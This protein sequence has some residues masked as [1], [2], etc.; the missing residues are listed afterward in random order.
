MAIV[1]IYREIV[2]IREAGERAA[3]A[4]I[5][6]RLG[7]TP[8]KDSAKM[9]I[10]EDGTAVGSVG[11]GCVEGEVWQKAREVIRSGRPH[12]LS[13]DLNNEDAANDGL[14]CGGRV[15]IFIE[16]IMSEERLVI[17]G[18]GHLGQAISRLA[19]QVD[20]KVTVA[21]DRE[22]FASRERFPEAERVVVTDF[23]T[24]FSDIPVDSNTFILIV[25]RGH[26]HDQIAT[27]QAV[28]TPARYVGLVGSRRKIKLIVESLLQK[29]LTPEHFRNLVAPIGLPIGSETP[30]EIAV[31]VVAELIAV[32]KG[33]HQRSEKQMWVQRLVE[34]QK[35][36]SEACQS[37]E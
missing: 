36:A 32:R 21:D 6:R 1:D 35:V 13:F 2:R 25:T 27:E 9:L 12:L 16:P 15:E 28:Q 17:L 7:S 31:S 34:G 14:V 37:S 26:S 29:G 8:R 10:R 11:G 20:F 33:V 30:E 3:L 22:S 19:G 4:T 5:V 23:G 18:A 24:A